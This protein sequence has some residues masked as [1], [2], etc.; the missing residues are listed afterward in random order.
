MSPTARPEASLRELLHAERARTAALLED[1]T[2]DFAAIA[3]QVDGTAT[4]DEHDPEGAT[5]GFERAQVA[6]L[7][8]RSRERLAEI[9]RA[10]A[11]G[12]DGAEGPGRTGGTGPHGVRCDV[13]GDEVPIA[14]LVARPGTTRCV[15][16]AD[17]RRR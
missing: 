17:A 14:R 4:D 7:L 11:A 16:C 1:L 15:T 12:T 2:R 10:L 6:A 13:C 5:L 3:A 9:D 8:R